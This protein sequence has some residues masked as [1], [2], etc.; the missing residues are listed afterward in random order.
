MYRSVGFVFLLTSLAAFGDTLT[1]KEVLDALEIPAPDRQRLESGN[2]LAYDGKQYEGT[3]RE[4]VTDAIVLI[5]RPLDDVVSEIQEVESI[6]PAKYLVEYHDIESLDDFADV[7]FTIDEIKEVDNLLKAKPGSDMNL[8][9]DEF[10]L[11]SRA[12]EQASKL[13]AEGRVK[14]ASDAMRDILIA[15]YQSYLEKGLDGIPP[16]KRSSRKSVSIGNELMLTT[17]T[18]APFEPEFPEY[19]RVMHDFPEGAD[20]CEH[21]FRWMKANLRKRPTFAL[22][23]TFLQRTDEFLLITERHYYV[24]NTLNSVQVTVSWIPYD[25]DTYMGLAVSASTD[26]LDSLMGRM[27]RPLGRNKA[28]DL[29]SDVLT[30]IRDDIQPATPD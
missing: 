24:S 11:L 6:I 4:L 20:C 23:H 7:A 13:D 18:F 16:Y 29:V 9:D 2:V 10:R 17:Q 8:S 30:E 12:R 5:D 28:R 15:R 1:G 14:V 19:Y 21:I 3:D 26:L 25:E 27:L 22:T